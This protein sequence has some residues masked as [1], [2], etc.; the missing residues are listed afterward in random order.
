M[1]TSL[2]VTLELVEWSGS[3]ASLLHLSCVSANKG[4]QIPPTDLQKL[5]LHL[6]I[7]WFLLNCSDVLLHG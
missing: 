2:H 1:S 6:I 3:S 5:L 7:S 4:R